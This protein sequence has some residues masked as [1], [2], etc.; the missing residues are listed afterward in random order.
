MASVPARQT[1]G[2]PPAETIEQKF[3]RLAALHGGARD[4]ITE[5]RRPDC[6]AAQDKQRQPGAAPDQLLDDLDED[7][8]S[9]AR[10][11]GIED[12]GTRGQ[13]L[14]GGLFASDDGRQVDTG[15]TQG[16]AQIFRA[17]LVVATSLGRER[18]TYQALSGRRI[19]RRCRERAWRRRFAIRAFCARGVES[20]HRP[21]DDHNRSNRKSSHDL[22]AGIAG[23][24][25]L[26]VPEYSVELLPEGTH[27]STSPG[28]VASLTSR[29]RLSCTRIC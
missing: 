5:Q 6:Q 13:G 11:R 21:T 3:E 14:D 10:P 22:P 29:S 17:L 26:C 8:Q 15:Q 12:D 18:L 7:E 27:C 23:L 28:T 20:R 9:V 4:H 25:V 16:L 24:P 19:C 2:V 1:A